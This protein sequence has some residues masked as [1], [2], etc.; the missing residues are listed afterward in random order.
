MNSKINEIVEQIVEQLIQAKDSY[1]AGEPV[2]SDSEF[3]HLEDQ[4]RAEDPN[5]AYFTRVGSQ[6]AKGK[7]RHVEPMLS[8]DKDKTP[9]GVKDWLRKINC[10]NEQ[11]VCMPK[12]DGL[13]GSVVY[14]R[15]NLIYIATRG[16]G[17]Q[18][19]DITHI[20]KF[21]N[22]PASVHTKERFEVRGEIYLRKDTSIPNPDN[23]SLRNLA[24]GLV[25][26]LRKDQNPKVMNELRFVA[27][28]SIGYV[29]SL[30]SK[31][32]HLEDFDF[33]V[34]DYEVVTIND[35]QKLYDEYL[36]YGR[37]EMQYETDGLVF[38]V[39]N[40]ELHEEIDSKYTI[41]HH[42][43]S[44]F[45]LKPPSDEKETTLIGINWS[46]S[47]YGWI[48]PV[49]W[50]D[51]IDIGGASVSNATLNNYKNVEKL[52]LHKGDTILICRS[53]DVIPFFKRK[54]KSSSNTD[55]LIPNLCPNCGSPLEKEGVHLVCR[56]VDCTEKH[57]QIISSWVEKR[58]MKNVSEETVRLLYNNGII[59]C[60]LDLYA[61]PNMPIK[62]LTAVRGLG[63]SKVENLISEIKKSRSM[64]VVQF[65]AA[66][67]IPS[68]GERAAVKLG[69]K[70]V[71]DFMEFKNDH[72][73]A[74]KKLI[75][76]LIG[77]R[78]ELQD[79][80]KVLDVRD[81]ESLTSNLK[82][83]CMTGT[84]PRKRG[85]LELELQTMGYQAIDDVKAGIGA[86]I[87]DNIEGT[88]GKLKKAR[89][90]GIKIIK[91]EDFFK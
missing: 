16:D 77:H 30:A 80:L 91:Y 41:S 11:L 71:N 46:V 90:L 57:I 14:D 27:Y 36:S 61:I 66:L 1:Y 26:P 45:A 8:L 40:T 74:G 34:V 69:I 17:K 84:G 20:A 65:M 63:D 68:I 24:A 13:S 53:G 43:Y 37:E 55:P 12:I 59:K 32:Q 39:N 70:T 82:L 79:L 19:Q 42:H 81:C 62:A 48:T 23:K 50:F 10:E 33:D 88:S 76:Y 6:Q 52:N 31:L 73:V 83:V 35:I 5:N 78:Q 56:N 87:C 85:D 64:T 25:N 86:L 58:K 67:S 29:E 38:T 18:G 75:G 2:M 89:K 60:I 9:D 51:S 44:S 49:A 22:I 21:L 3:D 4:L 72:S 15:G 47:K 7:I 28:N 54:V